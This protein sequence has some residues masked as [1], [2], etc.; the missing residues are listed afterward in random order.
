[1]SVLSVEMKR[2]NHSLIEAAVLRGMKD[3]SEDSYRGIRRLVD[4][5]AYFAHGRFTTEAVQLVQNILHDPQSPYF[6]LVSRAAAGTDERQLR[7]FVVNT[8]YNCWIDGPKTIREVKGADNKP[9]PWTL[10]LDFR[11]QALSG[12]YWS[13]GRL[14]EL[15]AEAE[16]LG[17]LAFALVAAPPALTET[18]AEEHPNAVFYYFNQA[19]DLSR[20]WLDQVTASGNVFISLLQAAAEPDEAT[21]AFAALLEQRQQ[22]YGLHSFYSEANH[23]A[24]TEQVYT[25]GQSSLNNSFAILLPNFPCA[26]AMMAQMSQA[27]LEERR[28]PQTWKVKLEFLADNLRISGMLGESSKPA[29][30]MG[31]AA[32][33]LALFSAVPADPA[34]LLAE[35]PA[36]VSG[37]LH[38]ILGLTND[39]SL[40]TTIYQQHCQPNHN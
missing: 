15:L 34:S 4:L 36:Y 2:I 21:L 18:L 19:Q 22:L 17:I 25:D 8:V 40:R 29:I 14:A 38:R 32:G 23:Q 31:D 16:S 35:A 5:V 7:H 3:I 10:V 26:T 33:H 20:N 11:L 24:I 27:V 12:G 39:G 13:D 37:S 1:M 9:L 6:A 28:Q 30:L